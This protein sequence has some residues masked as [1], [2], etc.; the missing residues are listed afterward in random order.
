MVNSASNTLIKGLSV[1]TVVS[2]SNALLQLIVFSLFSR[3]L[4]REDFGYYAALMGVVAIL[5]SIS[6]AGVGAS[7]IQKKD[8]SKSYLST[9]FSLSIIIGL[10]MAIITFCISPL[11]SRIVADVSVIIPLRLLSISVFLYSVQG[12]AVSILRRDLKFKEVGLCRIASYSIASIIALVYAVNG[13]G[14]YSLIVLYI[15][16]SILYTIFLFRRSS[17]PKL[18]VNLKDAKHVVSFGGWLTLGVIMTNIS[19]QLDKLLLGNWLSVKA[20]GEYN[21]PSGF[22]NNI[23]IMLNNILDTVL[24]PLLSRFQD[25]YDK[26]VT[27]FYRSHSILCSFGVILA[28]M[29]FINSEMIITLF[30]GNEW[31]DL[32]AVMRVT[33]ISAVFML[34]NTL[35]DCFF[36]SFNLVKYGFYIRTIGVFLSLIALYFGSHYGIIGVAYGVLISNCLIVLIKLGYL[37]YKSGASFSKMLITWMIAWKPAIPLLLVGI[38]LCFWGFSIGK[39]VFLLIYSIIV[40]LAE[41]MFWPKLFGDEFCGLILPKIDRIFKIRR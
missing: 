10:L 23:I 31:L 24:F 14:L 35:A 19:N 37:C 40:I 4:S 16:D 22:I 25:S 36:R 29:L 28:S 6:D 9:S 12:V 34:S 33:A 30:F 21:R 18:Q 38:P 32:V 11:V 3:I 17:V 13:G 27:L 26:F 39:I 7:I 15:L 5:T 8:V 20:L 41:I 2:F 1:Q